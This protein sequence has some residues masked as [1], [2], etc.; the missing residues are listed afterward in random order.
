MI[1]IIVIPFQS[2]TKYSILFLK[3]IVPIK[4]IFCNPSFNLRYTFDWIGSST[5]KLCYKIK[6]TM[7]HLLSISLHISMNA[8]AMISPFMPTLSN[9][10]TIPREVQSQKLQYQPQF[11]RQPCVD[12]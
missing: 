9:Y 4:A 8:Y 3:T 7:Y 5:S 11:D 10:L 12:K 2:H 1:P 6:F